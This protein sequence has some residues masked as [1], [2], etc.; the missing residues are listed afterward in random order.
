MND[1]WVFGYGSL[2][3]RPGFDF[4]E[5]VP[6]KLFGAHRSLCVLSHTHRG[7]PTRP[8]LVLG[9]DRGGSCLGVA[10]RVAEENG[11]SVIGYLRKRELDSDVYLETRRPVVISGL[12]GG[13]IS[14]LL[15]VV[16]QK[17]PQYAGRLPRTEALRI[18]RQGHGHSGPNRDYVVNTAN[19][20]AKLGIRDPELEWLARQLR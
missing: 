19:H 12:A 4:E 3:W 1:L 18:V 14:A 7:T 2:M 8:G 16:D 9:L 11:E 20:L 10:F 17:H 15:Y 6:A 13:A 5:A